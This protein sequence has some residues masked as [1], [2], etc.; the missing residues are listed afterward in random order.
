MTLD[1]FGLD[2]ID[3]L[4]W[5]LE[6]MGL[7]VVDEGCDVTLRV[8]VSGTRISAGYSRGGQSY[9]CWAG[10][11]M[12]GEVILLD[13]TNQLGTW[14]MQ[15]TFAPPQT[16]T[17]CTE[18]DASIGQT[19]WAVP[20]AVALTES[21]GAAAGVLTY[22]RLAPNTDWAD[23]HRVDVIRQSADVGP[24]LTALLGNEEWSVRAQAAAQI[25]GWAS[26]VIMSGQ[27]FPL[28]LWSTIPYLIASGV[29]DDTGG[30][31]D[32]QAMQTLTTLFFLSPDA[33]MP[34]GFDPNDPAAWWAIWAE[35][36]TP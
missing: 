4:R 22:L 8:D 9:T 15:R 32:F 2:G 25:E 27:Q 28:E 33:P 31:F 3:D 12:S 6:Q 16:I 10:Y 20:T 24:I 14:S 30:E 19:S 21:F 29:M 1:G 17:S 34:V 36:P 35:R 18:K 26:A 5:T 23:D 13:A 7:D 11:R